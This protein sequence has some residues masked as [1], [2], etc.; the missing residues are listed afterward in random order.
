MI[1]NKFKKILKNRSGYTVTELMIAIVI[2]SMISLAMGSLL[3]HTLGAWSRGT[4]GIDSSSSLSNTF[5]KLT[6]QIRNGRL[7]SIET[8]PKLKVIFPLRVHDNTTGEDIYD[9]SA[10]DP[11]PV[12]FYL[13]NGNL[14]KSYGSVGSNPQIIA[15]EVTSAT[16][17][18][19]GGTVSI[20]LSIR[21][22]LGNKAVTNQDICR[23]SLRN[24][25]FN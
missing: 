17:G 5:Q 10:N 9:L 13:Y 18:A 16:F 4:S 20:N 15:K 14:V 6:F 3:I 21:R 2:G 11:N 7:A 12:Y 8:G 19:Q 1:I 23:I 22:N 24:Y 25:R